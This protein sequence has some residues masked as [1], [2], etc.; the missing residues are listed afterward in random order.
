[1][2]RADDMFAVPTGGD[3]YMGNC[4]KKERSRSN[5]CVNVDV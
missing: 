1:M 3:L 4:A 2:N 5:D